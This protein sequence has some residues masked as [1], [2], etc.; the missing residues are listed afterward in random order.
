[1][2]DFHWL[3][4]S[5]GDPRA[6]ALMSRHYSFRPYRDGRRQ[7]RNN[8]NRFLFVGPGEKVVLL[9]RD[10]DALFVWRRF[11]DSDGR[12]VVHCAVFH[13]E[14]PVLSSELIR[15][16]E[17]IAWARWP[18]ETLWTYVDPRK[19]K[20]RNPGYCFKRAGWKRDGKTNGGLVVLRKDP[21]VRKP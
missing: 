3:P 17:G 12:R 20:S 11:L 13:N 16:A 9:T 1:M 7:N 18:G 19:I 2:F 5:D 6:F 14:S 10:C 4:S 21:E 15:E 8:P